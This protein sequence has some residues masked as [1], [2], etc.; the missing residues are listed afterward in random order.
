MQYDLKNVLVTGADTPVGERL[1]R[2]LLLDS[3]VEQILAVTSGADPLPIQ[4]S[5][6]LHSIQVDLR[7]S[8]RV[9]SLLFGYYIC[10]YIQYIYIYV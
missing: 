3:R 5:D 6:R 1:I 8:R 10:I 9:H 4:E 2:R 7:R